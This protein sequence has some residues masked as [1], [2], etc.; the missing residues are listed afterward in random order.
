M[1]LRGAR[2]QKMNMV[3]IAVEFFEGEIVLTGNLADNI[4]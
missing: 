1:M 3:E 4:A 2:N